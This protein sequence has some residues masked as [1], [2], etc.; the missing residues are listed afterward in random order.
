MR[1]HAIESDSP[2]AVPS[3]RPQEIKRRQSRTGRGDSHSRPVQMA[4]QKSL[5][6]SMLDVAP[7]FIGDA[8]EEHGAGVVVLAVPRQIAA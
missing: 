8:G 1:I 5:R 3:L 6:I 2:T 4:S 7:C